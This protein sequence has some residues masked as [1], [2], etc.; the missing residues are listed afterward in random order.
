MAQSSSPSPLTG[1]VAFYKLMNNKPSWFL[2]RVQ[3]YDAAAD[4]YVVEDVEDPTDTDE[5]T[6][7]DIMQ[8]PQKYEGFEVGEIVMSLWF[9]IASNLWMTELYPAVVI[10][11]I[12]PEDMDRHIAVLRF[13]GDLKLTYVPVERLIRIPTAHV[14]AIATNA[15]NEANDEAIKMMEP[16]QK[17]P[18]AVTPE[19]VSPKVVPMPQ[20]PQAVILW[21]TG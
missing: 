6:S 2:G 12:Q 14:A 7:N 15:I 9:D 17:V 20:M 21:K 18:K 3:A 1:V 13:I 8:F 19:K 4:K 5:V 10:S 16:V 11:V